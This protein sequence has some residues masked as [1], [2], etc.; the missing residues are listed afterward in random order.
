DEDAELREPSVGLKTRAPSAARPYNLS[1]PPPILPGATLGIAG[2][3]QLGRML[4]LAAR[5]LGYRVHIYSPEPDS[6]AGQVAD[7]ETVGAYEDADALAQFAHGVDALTFEFENI[8]AA[9]IEAAQTQTLVRPSPELL[10]I[11][12]HRL[13]EK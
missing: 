8:P 13:R 5:Q 11:T 6:P 12:Q 7:L 4:A 9:S 2:S 1:M 3:G 10:H